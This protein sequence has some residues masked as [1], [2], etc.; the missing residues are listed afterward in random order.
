M[1]KFAKVSR[2]FLLKS[3][4]VEY[5]RKKQIAFDGQAILVIDM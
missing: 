5:V 1:G 3:H 2:V 4:S